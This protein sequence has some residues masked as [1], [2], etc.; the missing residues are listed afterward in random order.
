MFEYKVLSL[1]YY[2]IVSSHNCVQSESIRV[3]TRIIN[4][5]ILMLYLI[6]CFNLH[7]FYIIYAG[8]QCPPVCTHQ[9]C[10][11]RANRAKVCSL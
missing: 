8:L 10:S 9:Y 6:R 2:F 7:I 4:I 11:K 3:D 5:R 1:S